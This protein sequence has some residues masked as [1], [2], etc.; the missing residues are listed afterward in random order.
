MKKMS[1]LGLSLLLT[2]SLTMPGLAQQAKTK[3]EYDAYMLFYN[4]QNLQKKGEA[5]EKFLSDPA[6]NNS[7]FRLPTFQG[8]VIA[9]RNSQNWAKVMEMADKLA[10]YLP[11][12][13]NTIKT[14]TYEQ[15]MVAG[16]QTGNFD[17]I[18]EYGDK[19]LEIN[20]NNVNA[21]ITLSSMLPERL[22][23]DEAAKK[24]ALDKAFDLATKAQ[25]QIPQIFGQK[26]AQFTDE[27]WARERANLEAQLAATFGL[28]HLNRAEYDLSAEKYEGALKTNPKDGISQYRIGL[29][30]QYQASEA[31]KAVVAAITAEN[32]AKAARAEEAVV[33]ELVSKRETLEADA[34]GKRDKAIDSFARAVAI[35]GVV[36]QP[37]REQLE[38]LYKAKNNDVLD[39]LDQLINDKKTELGV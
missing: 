28:I 15:A 30:Y 4:E 26:P 24:A 18:V 14:F 13:D 39:G 31:T 34:R 25:A 1:Y 12:A 3:A 37:A 8:A 20:P 9:Y 16:Q 27:Q 11:T 32:D 17:K 33:N 22:P 2:L 23:A 10:T 19:V 36:A 21:Q 6:Y 5:A 35:G 7:D 29:A 38:R